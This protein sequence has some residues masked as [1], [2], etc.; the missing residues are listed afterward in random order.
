MVCASKD[1]PHLPREPSW[2]LALC[3]KITLHVKNKRKKKK[4]KRIGRAAF[5]IPLE[6]TGLGMAAWGRPL[7]KSPASSFRNSTLF[8]HCR[9]GSLKKSMCRSLLPFFQQ[10]LHSIS[11]HALPVSAIPTPPGFAAPFW[12][13]LA[14][15]GPSQAAQTPQQH[16][17]CSGLSQEKK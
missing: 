1:K 12:Q 11:H 3:I 17:T 9:L 5:Q 7:D 15:A 13:L 16:R 2:P 14:P 6:N 10:V 8:W 4:K